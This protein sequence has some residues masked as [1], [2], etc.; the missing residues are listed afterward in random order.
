MIRFG[1]IWADQVFTIISFSKT[2]AGCIIPLFT[3]KQPLN[4]LLYAY[5]CSASE[6]HIVWVTNISKEV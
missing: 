2:D 3:N 6:I 4:C 1:L 5:L